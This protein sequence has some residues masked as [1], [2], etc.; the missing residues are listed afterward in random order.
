MIPRRSHN[1]TLLWLAYSC[2]ALPSVSSSMTMLATW[3]ACLRPRDVL[4]GPNA[5]YKR[6]LG[7][8]WILDRWHAK[9][10][11]GE[12]CKSNVDPSLPF[13]KPFIRGHNTEICESTNAWLAGFKHAVRHMQQ[14]SFK[15]HL[16][17]NMD[18]HNEILSVGA[19]SHLVVCRPLRG[20]Q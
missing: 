10:H 17:T 18:C 1:V 14:F 9:N 12:W 4:S 5:F 7:I 15:F 13:L 6:L 19:G 3:R 11:V 2:F 20:A 8:V 16:A